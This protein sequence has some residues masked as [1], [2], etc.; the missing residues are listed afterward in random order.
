MATLGGPSPALPFLFL[1]GK[2]VCMTLKRML[3]LM[4]A[5]L[6]GL[7]MPAGAA[8]GPDASAECLSCHDDE[9]R[10]T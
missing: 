1:V 9:D 2:G 6:L 7:A 8:T 10:P 3:V 5:G 4:G